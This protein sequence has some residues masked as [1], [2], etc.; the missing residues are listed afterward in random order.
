MAE[1]LTSV[2]FFRDGRLTDDPFPFYAALRDKC[3]VSREDH[4][5]VTMV[6]GWQEAVEVY[7]DADTFSSCIS[8]TGPFPGF[9][10]SLEGLEDGDITDLIVEHRDEI[11][12]SDQLPT[13]DPPTHTNHRAL[14]M[15]LITPKR[16]KENEDAMWQ[17][18]D[19]ILDDFLAPGQG[20]FISGFAAPFT[21]RVIADLLGVPEQDRP[22]LLERLA[23]G[24]HGGG[25]G[26]ADKTL[27][28]TPLE[29]LYDVFAEY[30]E[31]RRRTPREDVL[32]GLATATFPDGTV[33]EVGDVVRVATNVFSAGQETTVRLLSTALKVLGDRPDIQRK[34]REDRSLLPNFIEECLR[35]E[36]PVKGDFRLSRVPT[37]IGDQPLGAGCTVMVI[38]GAAN[39]D[40]RRFE[41][42]DSFDP[43]R[44]NARQHLAF[45]R[46]IHSCPGAPLA[47]AE[48][49]VGLERLLDRTTD[50]RISEAHHGPAGARRYNYIPTYILRGLT[51]LHLEF[52]LVDGDAG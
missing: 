13:L 48:T 22:E 7:N 11:P 31:D 27:T 37:Q 8:V 51:E 3:P 10:V 2:D 49:R 46:G 24:T 21:L 43:E 29:Y 44:K 14:L 40:P 4:Y 26:N 12:F 5:G 6:T 9:P 52:D 23:R 28:K 34:L 50:I 42:P 20:E 30:V 17:L 47:R 38:N 25:L 33:P 32:T 45:G 15:R 36:S 19:D 1:D 41:D 35:I 39:R 16:L 18:A